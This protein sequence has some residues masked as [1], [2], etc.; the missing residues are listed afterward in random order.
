MHLLLSLLI[1]LPSI[2]YSQTAICTNGFTLVNNKCLKL[3]TEPATRKD[4]SKTCGKYG[5]T[6]ATI[7]TSQ[8]NSDVV[9]IVANTKRRVW[10]GLYCLMNDPPTC[11]WDNDRVSVAKYNNFAPNFP[12]VEIGRCVTFKT[13]GKLAGKWLNVECEEDL[14]PFV[15][16]IPST[17]E[18]DCALN[19][20]GYCYIPSEG[21]AIG[22]DNARRSCQAVCADLISLHSDNEVRFIESY[23]ESSNVSSIQ[24][25]GRAAPSKYYKW[26]DQSEFD[27]NNYD[28]L[29]GVHGDCLFLALSTDGKLSKG[30]WYGDNCLESRSF[31]CKL[32]IGTQCD[33]TNTTTP[34]TVDPVKLQSVNCKYQWTS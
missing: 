9:T 4:A 13:D 10:I 22:F 30:S 2:S 3:F 23:Y 12:Y 24:I 19:Y 6:L 7:K 16:E 8:D 20:N 11:F 28:R 14:R 15:C 29:A 26:V 32:K 31:M 17:F 21:E 25:G 27:F 1:F 18:D 33:G 5:G 34:A